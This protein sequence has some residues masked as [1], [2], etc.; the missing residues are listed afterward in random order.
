MNRAGE[1]SSDVPTYAQQKSQMG[2]GVGKKE[3]LN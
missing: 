3:H 2:E 1:A